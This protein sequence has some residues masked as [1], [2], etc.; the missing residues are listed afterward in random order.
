MEEDKLKEKVLKIYPKPSN[1][2]KSVFHSFLKNHSNYFIVSIDISF[3]QM[4]NQ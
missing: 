1:I 4:I 3:F 2:E